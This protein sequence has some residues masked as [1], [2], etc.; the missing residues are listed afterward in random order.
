MI[1]RCCGAAGYNDFEYREI[2]FSCRNHVTGNNYIN[3]CAEEMSMYL[4]SKT[5][6]IAGIGL[7]LCL[8]QIFGILFAVCLCRAIKREAKDYQ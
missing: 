3:G 5:G 7:V 6:W 4:E 8:L 1:I 2:P